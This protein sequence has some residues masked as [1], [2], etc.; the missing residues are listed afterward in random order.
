MALIS[1]EQQGKTKY[2]KNECDMHVP[3]HQAMECEIH[4]DAQIGCVKVIG[5]Y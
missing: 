1:Q 3:T 4:I 5:V 2:R